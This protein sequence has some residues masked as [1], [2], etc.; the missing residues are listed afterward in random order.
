MNIT[1]VR[2]GDISDTRARA[3]ASSRQAASCHPHSAFTLANWLLPPRS[4][5]LPPSLPSPVE[6]LLHPS[7]SS[8]STNFHT[9]L[10]SLFLFVIPLFRRHDFPRSLTGL[11][12]PLTMLLPWLLPFLGVFSAVPT[13]AQQ[14]GKFLVAGDTQVSAM[15]VRVGTSLSAPRL[16][17]ST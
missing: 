13:L 4:P 17:P 2:G 15:M 7:E 12:L 3:Q 11:F 14:A 6:P 5:S 8:S 1:T 16:I 10:V 9:F